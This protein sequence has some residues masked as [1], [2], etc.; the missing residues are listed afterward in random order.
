MLSAQTTDLLQFNDPSIYNFVKAEKF[1][2]II[3]AKRYSEVVGTMIEKKASIHWTNLQS[4]LEHHPPLSF[5]AVFRPH[6]LVK[7]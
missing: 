3:Y 4:G 7:K 1:K 5:A 6:E 2:N